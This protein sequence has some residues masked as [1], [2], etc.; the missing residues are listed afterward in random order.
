MGN[1]TCARLHLQPSLQVMHN[2]EARMVMLSMTTIALS[3][4]IRTGWQ[5]LKDGT[6]SHAML[7]QKQAVM[8]GLPARQAFVAACLVLMLLCTQAR[9]LFEKV[10]FMA[11]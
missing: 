10:P 4:G 9:H 6:Q 7:L 3:E 2:R 1:I 11:R 5:L 8:L